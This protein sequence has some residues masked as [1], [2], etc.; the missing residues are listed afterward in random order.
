MV[1]PQQNVDQSVD[2]AQIRLWQGVQCS[3]YSQIRNH[4]AAPRGKAGLSPVSLKTPE[5]NTHMIVSARRF[6]SN[7]DCT[8]IMLEPA[9]ALIR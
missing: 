2:V 8:T 1:V 9:A 4:M 6:V 5:G 3:Q 7:F